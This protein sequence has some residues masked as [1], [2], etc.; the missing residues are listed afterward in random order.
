LALLTHPWDGRP[1][2]GSGGL[3]NTRDS[4]QAAD[5]GVVTDVWDK[6]RP[7]DIALLAD[8]WDGRDSGD[9]GVVI[10]VWDGRPSGDL[11]LLAVSRAVWESPFWWSMNVAAVLLAAMA[12]LYISRPRGWVDNFLVEVSL[13]LDALCRPPGATS[14]SLTTGTN[15]GSGSN[16]GSG[17][18]TGLL[19][20]RCH[21]HHARQKLGTGIVVELCGMCFTCKQLAWAL[22][23]CLDNAWMYPLQSPFSRRNMAFGLPSRTPVFLKR[24][25]PLVFM[26]LLPQV[27]DCNICAGLSLHDICHS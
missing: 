5:W 6:G 4:G 16:D 23:F 11:G 19:G 2:E 22:I 26:A 7:A 1:P 12:A 9:L 18:F 21:C 14:T 20:Q 27:W 15:S 17:R 25:L 10:D 13:L 3:A 24:L 8:A